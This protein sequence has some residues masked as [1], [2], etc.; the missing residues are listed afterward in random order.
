MFSL[1]PSTCSF[2]FA[3]YVFPCFTLNVGRFVK[4]PGY[5]PIHLD[6]EKLFLLSVSKENFDFSRKIEKNLPYKKSFFSPIILFIL[7]TLL[8]F[9]QI[10]GLEPIHLD[11]E[12]L[13]LPS[14][15]QENLNFRR[16]HEKPLPYE[17]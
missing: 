3:E 16:K 6:L 17:I 9:F 4:V 13:L 14:V 2:V 10:P 8:D 7:L 15:S 11:L 5:E 1:K 12:K